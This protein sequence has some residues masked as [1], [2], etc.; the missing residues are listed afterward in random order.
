M[1]NLVL[2]VASA[3]VM[4]SC[5]LSE[6]EVKQLVLDSSIAEVCDCFEKNQGDWLAYKQECT[7]LANSMLTIITDEEELKKFDESVAECDKY[8]KD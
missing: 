3:L 7:E 4:V 1:K 6:E 2:V 8:H 5:G